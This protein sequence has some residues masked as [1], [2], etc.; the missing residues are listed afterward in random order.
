MYRDK[1][2]PFKDK[3]KLTFKGMTQL[4]NGDKYQGNWVEGKEGVDVI[5]GKGVYVYANGSE[6]FGYFY[7]Q[8]IV[9]DGRIIYHNGD[10]Y[11]GDFVDEEYHGQG[12]YI[13]GDTHKVS[14]YFVAKFE[15][16]KVNVL[17]KAINSIVIVKGTCIHK[18]FLLFLRNLKWFSYF[19]YLSN[20]I[21]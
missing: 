6:F 16:N 11:E 8:K 1:G 17:I 14:G 15:H 18:R 2:V 9:G 21:R 19:Y 3:A 12:K 13:F 5:Q 4:P 20:P 7:N 10:I